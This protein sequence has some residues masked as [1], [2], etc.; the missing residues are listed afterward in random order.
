VLQQFHFL[1]PSLLDFQNLFEAAIKLLQGNLINQI[2]ARVT[3]EDKVQL[4][5]IAIGRLV[6]YIGVIITQPVYKK[7]RG[8]N[9][10]CQLAG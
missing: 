7:A 3:K 1:L 6:P 5:E 2:P 10:C 9:Y 8:I 4:R